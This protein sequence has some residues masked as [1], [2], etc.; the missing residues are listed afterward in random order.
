MK[1]EIPIA[2]KFAVSNTTT[3]TEKMSRNTPVKLVILVFAARGGFDKTTLRRRP[4]VETVALPVSNSVRYI[5]NSAL[6]A[7][8]GNPRIFPEKSSIMLSAI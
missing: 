1:N 6:E 2:K 3:K 8:R 5:S 7:M 4:V